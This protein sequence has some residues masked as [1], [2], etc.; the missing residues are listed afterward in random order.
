M[1]KKITCPVCNLPGITIYKKA[2]A[3]KLLPASCSNC[4]EKS[5]SK[6]SYLGFAAVMWTVFLTLLVWL[7]FVYAI[8]WTSWLPIIFF[9]I[10]AFGIDRL[11]FGTL[12]QVKS[13]NE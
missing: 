8:V 3:I 12:V 2:F 6:V 11:L 7:V 10:I 4:K 1:L 9:M 5:W 13:I